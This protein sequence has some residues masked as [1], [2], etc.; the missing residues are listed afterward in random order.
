[1]QQLGR[2]L[3]KDQ[4]TLQYGVP[5]AAP[6]T[7]YVLTVAGGLV[8]DPSE[9]KV[10]LFGRNRP[11][12]NVCVGED[13]QRVSRQHGRLNYEAGRWWVTTLGRL[14]IRF[15]KSHLLFPDEDSIPLAAGYTPL[16]VQG[17]S[18]R[19]HLLEVYVTGDDGTRP[20]R[21]HQESTQP[22]RVWELSADEKLG[23]TVVG[24]RYLLHDPHPLPLS[25]RQSAD[26]LAELQPDAGWTAKRVEHLVGGV[27]SRIS[28][29]GVPGLT[30][31]EVGEPVGNAL[32]DNLFRELLFSTTLVPR[33]LDVLDE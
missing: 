28:R 31:E 16:F 18:G 19:E 20:V 22:P 5:S 15:P 12:V 33:D 13:D 3:P 32:N 14:P 23:L 6:G 10:I 24:Q 1:M 26:Q 21:R 29:G 11:E 17:A 4:T 30:R 9:G 2:V 25:W 7:I 27:R 8:V